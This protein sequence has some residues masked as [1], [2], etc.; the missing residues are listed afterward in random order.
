MHHGRTVRRAAAG[1][2]APAHRPPLLAAALQCLPAGCHT[3]LQQPRVCCSACS[4]LQ[5][6]GKP[7]Q[8]CVQWLLEVLERT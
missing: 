5:G 3:K 8:A 6:C 7:L 1:A 4:T 2:V